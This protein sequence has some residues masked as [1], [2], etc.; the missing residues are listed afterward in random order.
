MAGEC[1]GARG[2]RL[3]PLRHPGV[4]DRLR[5]TRTAAKRWH[6]YSAPHMP[7]PPASADSLSDAPADATRAPQADSVRPAPVQRLHA[8][9]N[10][11]ATMMWLGVVLHVAA[12]HRID[13]AGLQWHDPQTSPVANLLGALIHAFRMPVFFVVA[14]FFVALLVHRRGVGGMLGNRALR[15]GLPF[16]LFWPP[17]FALV[18]VVCTMQAQPMGHWP[19]P[20][21]DLLTVP[22]TPSGARLQALHLW[23]LELLMG[24]AVLAALAYRAAHALPASWRD[25][26]ARGLG[27][28]AG[29]WGAFFLLSLPL[30]VVGRHHPH[31]ILEADGEFLPAL[32]LWLHYGLFFAYGLVLHRWR[33]RLL[34]LLQ[35]RMG[36]NALGG[37]ACLAI[38]LTLA[39]MAMR[40]PGAVP[41]S[42]IWTGL[43]YGAC[44]WLWCFALIGA[45]LRFLPRRNALLAYLAAS[46]YWGYLVHLPVI[47]AVGL[48]LREWAAP[49]EAK[50]L[51]N[52]AITTLI[53]LLSY[54]GLVRRTVIGTLLGAPRAEAARQ[55]RACAG[56]E[57]V[58]STL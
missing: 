37:A 14:G 31:G 56:G 43:A 29:H 27:H 47:G 24:L 20:G 3:S 57:P 4:R 54:E 34:P 30:A 45:F 33:E 5:G 52:V 53:C 21:F 38:A 16:L 36:A 25:S 1:E 28:L 49:F 58:H 6:G 41:L 2:I 39:A 46:S 17:L 9:D 48:L 12:L 11:R 7:G 55:R 22:A 44:G 42:R 15:I 13:V 26:A 8:L 23:F 10:L 35:Q 32:A 18:V 51:V 40:T 19:V 50:L